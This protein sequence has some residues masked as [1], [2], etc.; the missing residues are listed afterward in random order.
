MSDRHYPEIK[1]PSSLIECGS[2]VAMS[3][4]KGVLK[5]NGVRD[6]RVKRFVAECLQED[7]RGVCRVIDQWVSVEDLDECES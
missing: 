5:R 6:G 4:V 3:R 1:I 2:I 7:S